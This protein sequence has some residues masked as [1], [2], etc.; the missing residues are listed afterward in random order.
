MECYQLPREDNTILEA[1]TGLGI[2]LFRNLS[3]FWN[4]YKY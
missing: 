4:K 2:P 3:F 1:T